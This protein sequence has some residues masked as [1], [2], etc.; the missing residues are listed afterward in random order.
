MHIII[1]CDHAG[2]NL[3]ELIINNLNNSVDTIKDYGTNNETSVDY[4]DFAHKVAQAIHEKQAT[5]GILI[6][7]TGNGVAITANKYLNVRAGLCWS[8]EIA[9]LTRKHN[10]ANLLCL[11]ARFITN[12]EGIK[13]VHAF[14]NTSFEGGRHEGRVKKIHQLTAK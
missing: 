8:T 7:G 2:F 13:I 14:L 6:C 3:K 12:E 4:P 1:G 9:E 5:V 11:P 10:D